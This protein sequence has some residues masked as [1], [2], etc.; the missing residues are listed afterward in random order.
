MK[1]MVPS[2]SRR[3]SFSGDFRRFPSPV[4]KI[5]SNSLLENGSRPQRTASRREAL[6][7]SPARSSWRSSGEGKCRFRWPDFWCPPLAVFG[8]SPEEV[9]LY[10]RLE[11]LPG[12]R[13][14]FVHPPPELLFNFCQLPPQAFAYCV[15][16]HRKV[17]VPVLPA[18]MRESQKVECLGLPFA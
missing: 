6:T 1:I 17:P 12:C 7:R 5:R 9:A 11:P 8:V 10:D 13:H 4:S 15:T 16:L 2:L 14:R 18:D 3:L